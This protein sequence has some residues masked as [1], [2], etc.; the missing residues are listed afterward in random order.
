MQR[1]KSWVAALAAAVVIT[2]AAAGV[3]SAAPALSVAAQA[4]EQ[5]T[6]PVLGGNIDKNVYTDY[7][8]KR[9]YFCCAA[10][11]DEFNKNPKKYLQ[12]LKEAGVTPE[13]APAKQ[14]KVNPQN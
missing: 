6:C 5:T 1:S 8:G 10:C 2:F 9:I 3:V 11:V 7:Q 12:K 4:K 13:A 14:G